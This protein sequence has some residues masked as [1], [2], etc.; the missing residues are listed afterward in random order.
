M[1]IRFLLCCLSAGFLFAQS[2]RESNDDSRVRELY[3]SAKEA[4][5]RGALPEA[6]QKYEEIL[7]VAPNLGAAYNNL[8][9]LYFRERDYVRAAAVLE[10]G[11]KVNPTMRSAIALL[12]I[13]LYNTGD[14]AGARDRLEAA[15]R[16]DPNDN[17]ARLFLSKCLAKLGSFPEAEAQLQKLGERDPRNQEVWYLLA[18][19]HMKLSEQALARMNAID[20]NSALAH[21][22]SGEVM[23]SMNNYDGAVV[24]LKKAVTLAPNAPGNHYRLG[25]AYWNLSQWDAATEQFND[26]LRVDPG[27][28]NAAWKL[29]NI[30]LEKNGSAADALASLD[31]A[32]ARCP[33]L[34]DARVDRARALVK[35]DRASEAVTDLQK[36]EAANPDDPGVHFLLAK[37]Y[38]SLGRSQ[39]AQ[40]EMQTFS[41]LDEQA[42]AAV[43]EHAQQVIKN[44]EASH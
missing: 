20:P 13:S 42:R 7:R 40:S 31:A 39:E 12:G 41:R 37:V 6:I 8:G 11:L 2:A 33:T 25:D 28:C 9:A 27:N 22:L 5:N 38:R 21:Q 4:Q 17:N 1:W 3:S 19:I 36:A 34:T 14:Y 16:A 29:G 43:A 10:R 32:L 23:E 24:E 30:I 18:K 15:V 35:L 26:E 44:R